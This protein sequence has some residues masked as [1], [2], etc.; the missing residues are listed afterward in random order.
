M[1]ADNKH[2]EIDL[3][4]RNL[5][6]ETNREEQEFVRQWTEASDT[7]KKLYDELMAVWLTMDKTS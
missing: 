2:I 3:L 6:G 1:N 4:T 5:A 7:N